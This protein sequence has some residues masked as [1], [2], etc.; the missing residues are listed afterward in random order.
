MEERKILIVEENAKHAQALCY[1]LE[2][3]RV[4]ASCTDDIEK[5]INGL[6]NEGSDCIVLDMGVINEKVYEGTT[7]LIQCKYQVYIKEKRS[8]EKRKRKEMEKENKK[9]K[10]GKE[11]RMKK[12]IE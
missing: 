7:R 3:Y 5:A 1:F 2:S 4:N 12:I 9:K 8:K 6:Q 10:E 11:N